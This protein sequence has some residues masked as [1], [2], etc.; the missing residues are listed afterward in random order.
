VRQNKSFLFFSCFLSHLSHCLEVWLT[1]KG[2]LTGDT[3]RYAKK[4]LS[5]AKH[6]KNCCWYEW[7]QS[8]ALLVFTLSFKGIS[9]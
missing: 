5:T 9:R 3:V 1:H 4:S 7:G 8:T 6:Y 2:Q